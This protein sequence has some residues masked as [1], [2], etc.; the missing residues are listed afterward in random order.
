VDDNGALLLLSVPVR[1]GQTLLLTNRRTEREMDCRVVRLGRR[2]SRTVETGVVFP[3][4][5][6]NFWQ[7]IAAPEDD[8]AA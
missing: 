5:E 3:Q 4:T 8:S 7:A 2:H 1:E 6:S